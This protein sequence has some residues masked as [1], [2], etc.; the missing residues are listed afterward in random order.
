MAAYLRGHPKLW[1]RFVAQRSPASW[2][3]TIDKVN[4]QIIDRPKLLL[5]DMK[6][7]IQPVLEPG[8]YYPHHNL[9]YVISEAWDMEVLGGLLLSRIAQ[10]FIEAYCVRMRGGTLRFQAQ[11]LKQIRVPAPDAIDPTVERRLRRAFRN[12]DTE[13]ANTAAGQA[14]DIDLGAYE[15]TSTA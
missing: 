4:A 7:T 6:A 5:Q 12:R 9:Y 8:G 13:A 10:A 2:Y 11:Y 15:L 1:D 3:R 14:Y